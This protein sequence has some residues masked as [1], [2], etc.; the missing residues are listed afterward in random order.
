M[1]KMGIADAH[2]IESF[3]DYDQK[4]ATILGMRAMLNRQR[5]AV[6]Y[7]VEIDD[8][9]EV[10]AHIKSGDY[11]EALRILK[12]KCKVVSFPATYA[13][14]FAKSWRLIP[15]AELDPF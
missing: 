5:H 6:L 15:N 2:G 8:A 3:L 9:T 14:S 12:E 13:E 10:E 4:T 11:E 1:K 7:V